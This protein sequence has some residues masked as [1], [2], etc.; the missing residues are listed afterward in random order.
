MIVQRWIDSTNSR[1]GFV[2]EKMGFA[3]CDK[4]PNVFVS[5]SD[6]PPFC[7]PR[8]A[9]P[10]KHLRSSAKNHAADFRKYEEF[11]LNGDIFPP[12]SGM[13]VTGEIGERS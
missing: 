10:R 8:S 2:A 9:F 12:S 3:P 13:K 11:R 1:A 4:P 5:R 7:P 6:Y